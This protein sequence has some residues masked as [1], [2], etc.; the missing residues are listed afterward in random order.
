MLRQA[1][2]K[3]PTMTSKKPSHGGRCVSQ[4]NGRHIRRCGPAV[5][6]SVRAALPMA[7]LIQRRSPASVRT[8]RHTDA[9]QSYPRS[10]PCLKDAMYRCGQDH[11]LDRICSPINSSVL[12][13]SCRRN[14]P[15]SKIYPGFG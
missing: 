4:G 3:A 13:A 11:V 2:T 7:A 8:C 5:P 12:P 15:R 1:A 6:A 9:P 10:R 14:L